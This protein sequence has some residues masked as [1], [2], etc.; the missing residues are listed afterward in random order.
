ML[1]IRQCVHHFRSSFISLFGF[2]PLK[3]VYVKQAR[4]FF[5]F[6]T[7]T[8]NYKVFLSYSYIKIRNNHVRKSDAIVL[9]SFW[10]GTFSFPF[11]F[12]FFF[13]AAG[14]NPSSSIKSWSEQYHYFDGDAHDLNVQASIKDKFYQLLISPY[15]P[16]FFCRF[17]SECF[18]NI[19]VSPGIKGKSQILPAIQLSRPLIMW[20]PN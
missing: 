5:P 2:V 15:V 1:H 18:Q 11:S 10:N 4:S 6:K 8:D 13:N 16:P 9:N 19:F 20:K 14:V 12:S 7:I 17:D 3:W